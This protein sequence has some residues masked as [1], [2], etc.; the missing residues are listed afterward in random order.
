[1]CKNSTIYPIYLF[2]E[3][4]LLDSVMRFI[5][6]FSINGCPFSRNGEYGVPTPLV[7]VYSSIVLSP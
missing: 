1:M 3:I 7:Y 4:P 2:S 5:S 6:K